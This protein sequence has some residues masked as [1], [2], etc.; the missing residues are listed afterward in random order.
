[1]QINERIS[2]ANEPEEPTEKW[3]VQLLDLEGNP[4][5]G[6]EYEMAKPIEDDGHLSGKGKTST[7]EKSKPGAAKDI[8]IKFG[9]ELLP[10]IAVLYSNYPGARGDPVGTVGGEYED[11]Y[12]DARDKAIRDTGDAFES[13]YSDTCVVR[14]SIAFNAAAHED[15]DYVMPKD[16]KGRGHGIPDDEGDDLKLLRYEGDSEWPGGDE[17]DVALRVKEFE[18][19]IKATYPDAPV[20][21]GSGSADVTKVDGVITFVG[22]HFDI[23]KGGKVKY[24]DLSLN[25]PN[26][27]GSVR[28]YQHVIIKPLGKTEVDEDGV[29]TFKFQFF[30]R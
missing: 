5:E 20:V 30:P 19:Y 27:S 17:Y 6:K 14:T 22:R 2:N 11:V 16:P 26:W 28:V 8:E 23:I 12:N 15:N 24:N 7:L 21:T 18:P 29:E 25:D 13:A 10:K 4:I 1:V 9:L 3:N